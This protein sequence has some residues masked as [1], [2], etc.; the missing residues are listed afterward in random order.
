MMEIVSRENA[1]HYTWGGISDSWYLLKSTVSAPMSLGDR[2][3][4]D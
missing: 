4:V 1:E 3:L 2:A